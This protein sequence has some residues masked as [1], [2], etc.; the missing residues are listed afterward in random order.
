MP[1]ARRDR[2]R[3]KSSG[4][5]PVSKRWEGR[6]LPGLLSITR[7]NCDDC[8]PD[9]TMSKSRTLSRSPPDALATRRVVAPRKSEFE[10]PSSALAA[11]RNGARR[12]RSGTQ[13]VSSGS[14]TMTG[15]VAF[16]LPLAAA[17]DKPSSQYRRLPEWVARQVSRLAQWLLGAPQIPFRATE[18]VIGDE[19]HAVIRID[20]TA[21]DFLG[22]KPGDE[23]IV[24]W[25]HQQTN[26][27]VLL[28]SSELRERM[29]DQFAQRTGRQS[30]LSTRA[31]AGDDAKIL[32]HL[33]TWLSPSVRHALVIP[34]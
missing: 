17:D 13:P 20:P 9:P 31:K 27:R 18:S 16:L 4:L 33:Q 8:Q 19:G 29:R 28:Q 2:C 5:P 10:R 32:W 12:C 22:V 24:S 11:A 15:G 3:R 30:R 34:P 7:L 25:A 14:S 1:P 6:S 26:A 23:V 21:L